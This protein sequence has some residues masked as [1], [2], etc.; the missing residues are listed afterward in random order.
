MS[1]TPNISLNTI[2]YFITRIFLTL[3]KHYTNLEEMQLT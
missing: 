2:Q 3:I 1:L